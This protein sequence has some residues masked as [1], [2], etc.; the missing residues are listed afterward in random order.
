MRDEMLESLI[1]GRIARRQP[2]LHRLHRFPFAVVEEALD[3]PAGAV[4]LRPAPKPPGHPAP[5]RCID[6][7]S[8]A[9]R[10]PWM[11]RRGPS[12]FAR[13][14]KQPAN[15]S[16]NLPSRSSTARAVDSDKS[17]AH[18]H[19][20]LLQKS[21]V[22]IIGSLVRKIGSDKV[23]LARTTSLYRWAGRTTTAHI[24]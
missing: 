10:G 9:L 19:T 1:G 5:I 20:K 11:F 17:M 22:R 13:R 16:R 23:L 24:Q 8:V 18:Q 7:R 3:V 2:C 14:P 4:P 12:R 15:R 6:F 21:T